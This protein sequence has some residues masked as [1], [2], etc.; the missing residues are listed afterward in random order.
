MEMTRETLRERTFR[1]VMDAINLL[2]R[3]GIVLPEPVPVLLRKPEGFLDIPS[4]PSNGDFATNFP[5][6]AAKHNGRS[7][8]ELAEL[9]VEVLGQV[10]AFK[11]G[12]FSRVEI[13]GP[14][15]VNFH[16]SSQ[17]LA[18]HADEIQEAGNAFGYSDLHQGEEVMLEFFQP[19]IAKPLHVGH[20]RSAMV[21]HA[22]FLLLRSQGYSTISDTHYGDW[23]VQFGILLNAYLRLSEEEREAIFSDAEPIDRLNELYVAENKRIEE[24]PELRDEGKALFAKLEAGDEELRTHWQRFVDVSL[25]AYPP[26]LDWLGVPEFTVQLGESFY[27][28][29]MPADLERA[30]KAPGAVKEGDALYFDL[31]DVGLGRC[32]LRKTDGSTT[33]HAR[34]ISTALYR[35]ENPEWDLKRNLYFVGAEQSHHFRQLFEVLR[36]MEVAIA[37]V[38]E[39]VVLGLMKLPE[40][41]FSTRKG[42]IIRATELFK[43]TERRVLEVINE[44]NPDLEGKEETAQRVAVSVLKWWDLSHDHTTSFV[45][46]WDKALSFEGNT[47]PYMQYT[48]ARLGSIL[49]KAASEERG[50]VLAEYPFEEGAAEL[51]L[52]RKLV[53]FEDVVRAAAERQEP[54]HVCAYLFELAQ[55]ANAYYTEVPV[56]KEEDGSVRSARLSVVAA[57]HQVLSN[58]LTLLGI[59]VVEEM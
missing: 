25:Q 54:H 35:E 8:R 13:A 4:D 16:L 39:H 29:R 27:E 47:G 10:S 51:V 9:F 20:L 6:K 46:E 41:K 30:A 40:G 23:G 53:G 55:A 56:L 48:I 12:L 26:V 45:F 19:N 38:S 7:P 18:R 14:G 44:K 36:R 34:D 21:G 59:P 2:D 22:C 33:Y 32:Y 11:D 58:G 42:N 52:L 57:V 15:F 31:E 43:E 3:H 1:A 28:S 17:A 24:E 49:N 37:D 5:L 50:T